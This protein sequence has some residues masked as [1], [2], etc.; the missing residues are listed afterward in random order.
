[1]GARGVEAIDI[2]GDK[3]TVALVYR[4]EKHNVYVFNVDSGAGSS[5]P[6]VD[7]IIILHISAAPEDNTF[8]T[9]CSRHIKIMGPPISS[10]NGVS[11]QQS[12]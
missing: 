11:A 9:V 6:S 1:M 4:H 8:A 10:N 5:Q 3:S 2:S 7:K 12:R